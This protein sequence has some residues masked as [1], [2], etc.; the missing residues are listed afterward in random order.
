MLRD[1]QPPPA[2]PVTLEEAKLFLRVDHDAEDALIRT[3]IQS[4][5]ERLESYLGLAMIARPMVLDAPAGA[6]IHLPRWP[7]SSVQ[8][9]R[10]DG[11]EAADYHVDLRRRPSVVRVAATQSVEVAFTAGYGPDLQD[12]PAPLRQATLLLVL[13]SYEARGE[14]P[15]HLPL[16]VD[17]LT[18]P[19][20]GV[21]L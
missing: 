11:T 12:V 4:A 18:L 5:R 13:Q 16:M 8:S 6:C 3:L 7:V 14:T 20:K 10:A 15:S 2:E 9:V 1:I 21:G 19:Y 17:A